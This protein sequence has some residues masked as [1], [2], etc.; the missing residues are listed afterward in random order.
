M[1]VLEDQPGLEVDV[2]VD[3]TTLTE[4]NSDEDETT[5]N[6]ITKYIVARS[7]TN[8][9]VRCR[10]TTGRIFKKPNLAHET[11]T[12]MSGARYEEGGHFFLEKFAFSQLDITDNDHTLDCK[13]LTQTLSALGQLEIRVWWI[14]VGRRGKNREKIN[15]QD[16]GKKALKGRAVSHNMSLQN[17]EATKAFKTSNTT[18]L[19]KDPFAT[20]VFKYR[21]TD[22]LKAL[23]II[24]RSPTPVALENRPIDVLTPEE[25]RASKT[26]TCITK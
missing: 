21:S 17:R 6:T 14:S 25:M 22:A 11:T 5:V 3:G 26:T 7:G 19:E 23:Y 8:F 4:F 2:V 13:N 12:I 10:F 15:V 20:F 18:Y 16:I 24:P 1:A 9:E